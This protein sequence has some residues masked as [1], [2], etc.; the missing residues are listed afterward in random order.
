MAISTLANACIDI[1]IGADSVALRIPDRALLLLNQASPMVF[2]T[3]SL[4][5]GGNP[6]ADNCDP[7]YML[8]LSIVPTA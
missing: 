4:S 7:L 5:L 3:F 8:C 2:P 6:F 1:H